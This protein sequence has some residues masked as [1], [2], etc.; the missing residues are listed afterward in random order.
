[1]SEAKGKRYCIREK[2]GCIYKDIVNDI[3]DE[4]KDADALVVGSPVYFSSPNGS[5]ISLLDRLFHSIPYSLQMKV[6]AS[7]VVCRRGGNTA[8]FDVLNKYFLI[9]NMVLAPSNYWN[10]V[11][12]SNAQGVEQDLEGLATLRNLARNIIFL[13]NAIKKEKEESG[14][15]E[16]ENKFRTNFI[17]K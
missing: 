5:L 4:L 16:V 11:H 3:A 7:V 14:L 9:R 13:V 6:G 8:S 12:G 1:M 17:E 10:Q 15:P 2:K